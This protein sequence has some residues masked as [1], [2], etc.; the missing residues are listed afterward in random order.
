[1]FIPSHV[2]PAFM[3]TNKKFRERPFHAKQ[4]KYILFPKVDMT[5][6]SRQQ[7]LIVAGPESISIHDKR[8]QS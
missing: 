1:V 6:N 2:R 7:L 4:K 8:V 3:K 5:C